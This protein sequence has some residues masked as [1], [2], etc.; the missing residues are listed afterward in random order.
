MTKARKARRKKSGK[1]G[2]KCA[3]CG[4]KTTTGQ[5]YCSKDCELDFL[6]SELQKRDERL[7][8]LTN[9]NKPVK[10]YGRIDWK[11]CVQEWYTKSS[12]DAKR[13]AYKLRK[14]GFVCDAKS[15]GD[16]PVQ[17]GES[18]AESV[19]MT[20]LTCHLKKGAKG[21]EAPPKPEIVEEGL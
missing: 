19:K 5:A 13:R 3:V 8:R 10:C 16:M 18:G 15:I 20:V 17:N 11:L 12:Y 14:L 1:Q 9:P 21:L 2:G 6:K 4:K 7:S